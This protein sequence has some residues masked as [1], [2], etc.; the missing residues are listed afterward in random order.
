[1]NT[2]ANAAR[3]PRR[4]RWRSIGE[5]LAWYVRMKERTESA[6]TTERAFEEILQYGTHVSSGR[7]AGA[8][9]SAFVV[10]EQRAHY[11]SSSSG[12]TLRD[13][14]ARG[15][16]SGREIRRPSGRDAILGDLALI[17]RCLPDPDDGQG[18][19]VAEAA[20]A[21]TLLILTC[22]GDRGDGLSREDAAHE[23]RK[24]FG[25]DERGK[26]WTDERCKRLLY[27]A[28]CETRARMQERGL[29]PG[30]WGR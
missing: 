25:P 9:G 22:G 7:R 23:C 13:G 24:R 17:E 5:A 11:S 20:V 4:Y 26:E 27:R 12:I 8:P 18:G 29:L 28:Q 19:I 30:G 1:M 15:G 21:R 2:D 10:G 14:Q 16:T 6:S 3:E